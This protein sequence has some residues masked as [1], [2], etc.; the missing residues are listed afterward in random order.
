MID[1]ENELLARLAE[2]RAVIAGPVQ[3]AAQ[4]GD[5]P[6]LRAATVAVFTA[7]TCVPPTIP[8][9]G[10]TVL[11][12]RSGRR[13]PSALHRAPPPR[14]EVIEDYDAEDSSP[15]FSRVPLRLESGADKLGRSSVPS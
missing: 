9:P 13:G 15:V 14:P 7:F 4:S 8:S 12:E 10:L 11:R 5:V 2:L 3:R 6:A 1:S